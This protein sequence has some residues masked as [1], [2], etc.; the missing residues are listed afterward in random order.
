VGLWDRPHAGRYLRLLS[1]PES[2]AYRGCGARGNAHVRL[3][4]R[5]QRPRLGE[6][7]VRPAKAGLDWAIPGHGRLLT[8]DEIRQYV[9]N[10]DDERRDEGI[11]PGLSDSDPHASFRFT[12]LILG[13]GVIGLVVEFL[14]LFKFHLA[15]IRH[16]HEWTCELKGLAERIIAEKAKVLGP[17]ESLQGTSIDVVLKTVTELQSHYEASRKVRMWPV[18]GRLVTRI[19]GSVGILGGQLLAFLE[20]VRKV[21]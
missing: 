20:A 5:R 19:W 10:V 11:I 2:G 9:Q 17:A 21:A 14:P 15:I 18:D 8:K 16:R 4:R 13:V 12:P 6:R 3:Q 7:N 1:G